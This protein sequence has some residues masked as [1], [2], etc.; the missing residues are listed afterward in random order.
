MEGIKLMRTVKRLLIG[1][2]ALLCLAPVAARA[3]HRE[4]RGRTGLPTVREGENNVWIERG[5]V[6]LEVRGSNLYTTQDF[7]LHYPGGKLEKGKDQVQVAVREDYF[8]SKDGGAG[9]V[10]PA[11]AR[12]FISFGVWIDNHRVNTTTTSWEMNDKKDTATRWRNWWINFGPGGVH[13]MRVVSISPLGWE[14]NRRSVQFVSKDLGR[15]RDKPDFLEIKVSLP[16]AMEARLAGLE[17]KPDD[18]NS[19]GIRW[20]YRK[21]D[22]NRDVFIMLPSDYAPRRASR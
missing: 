2:A 8:R 9:D 19:K 12:G 3:E 17:P 18:V 11:E 10:T 14:G 20:V 16:G 4:F 21:A 5:N 1:A 7:R 13:T 22:P 15:W 6:N